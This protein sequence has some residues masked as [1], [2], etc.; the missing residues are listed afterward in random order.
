MEGI[1]HK[2]GMESAK[3]RIGYEQIALCPSGIEKIEFLFTANEGLAPRPVEKIASGG[4]MSRVMLALKSIISRS[5]ALPTIIFDEIDTGVSG[6]VANAMGEVIAELSQTMQV[7]DITHLP[8]I[9]SKGNRH[10]LVYKSD[11]TTNM[12]QL[13]CS[14]RVTEIAKMLSGENITEAAIKQAEILLGK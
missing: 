2:V 4:E 1:L 6:S 13:S 10:Y 7:I 12:R 3:F 5:L 8:Q 9:A 14:E 11:S